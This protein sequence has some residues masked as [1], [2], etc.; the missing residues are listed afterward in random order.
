[1]N[2]VETPT[3]GKLAGILEEL[4]ER[5]QQT[6]APAYHSLMRGLVIRIEELETGW[7]VAIAREW[8]MEPSEIEERTIVTHLAPL[9]A[10]V[11][12]RAKKQPGRDGRTYNVS[13]LDYHR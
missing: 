4:E 2:A 6:G 5:A 1:M 9:F 10:G 12:H 7:Q 8:P 11:W 3:K 13:R